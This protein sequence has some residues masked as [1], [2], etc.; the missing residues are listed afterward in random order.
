VQAALAE[1]DGDVTALISGKQNVDATLTALAG[2]T[3]AAD[4]LIYATGADTFATTTFTAAGRAL[5][6]DADATAQRATLTAA[7]SGVNN[8]ITEL[9]GLTAPLSLAQGG[10]GVTTQAAALTALGAALNGVSSKID[11]YTVIAADRGKLIDYTDS[12]AGFVLTLTAAAT[13]G[14]GF[15]VGVRNSGTGTITIDPNASEQIDGATTIALAAGQSCL[16]VCTGTAWKTLGIASTNALTLNGIASSGFALSG[17]TH[18]YVSTDANFGI[19]CFIVGNK[20]GTSVV[21]GS[22]YSGVSRMNI[23]VTSNGGIAAVSGTYRAITGAGWEG[24]E[25]GLLQR[26]A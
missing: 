3:T 4:K 16:C 18:S 10:T 5:V 21:A 23:G 25:G 24:G 9:T 13:L 6:D 11:N 8:D 26:I 12:T 17:H 22:T 19:G 7:K 1:I 20:P 14:A 2:V 15:V